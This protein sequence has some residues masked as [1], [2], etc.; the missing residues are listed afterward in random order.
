MF[1]TR[2]RTHFYK[3]VMIVAIPI[4]IQNGITNFVSMLDNLM[5]GALG[6]EQI[7]G[8]AIANQ[9]ALIFYLAVFGAMS[10]AGRAGEASAG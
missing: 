3:K 8:V 9:L 2:E 6:T 7:S 1:L 5:V 4:M 10:G